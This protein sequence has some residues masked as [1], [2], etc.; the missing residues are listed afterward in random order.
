MEACLLLQ[1]QCCAD[2]RGLSWLLSVVVAWTVMTTAVTKRLEILNWTLWGSC[3][4]PLN[5]LAWRRCCVHREACCGDSFI[6]LYIGLKHMLLVT[7]LLSPATVSRILR[8]LHIATTTA[9][10][11]I[12]CS[13]SMLLVLLTVA[14]SLALLGTLL[15]FFIIGRPSLSATLTVRNTCGWAGACSRGISW[16]KTSNTLPF[17]ILE[18]GAK[19]LILLLSETMRISCPLSFSVMTLEVMLVNSSWTTV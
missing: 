7:S 13:V 11:C 14:P 18:I 17:I 10:G 4:L 2:R 15:P 19:L 8:V 12:A 9:T 6:E 3:S 5:N 16:S 1:I